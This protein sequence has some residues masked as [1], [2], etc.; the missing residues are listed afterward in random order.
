MDRATQGVDDNQRDKHSEQV[1]HKDSHSMQ[2]R[3]SS[4]KARDRPAEWER[5]DRY[6]E[7]YRKRPREN[8]GQRKSDREGHLEGQR[9]R[10]KER[11]KHTK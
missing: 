7:K 10:Q 1:I 2:R 6:R 11:K 9:E 4:I 5:D 8:H 3:T